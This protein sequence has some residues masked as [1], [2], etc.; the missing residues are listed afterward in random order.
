MD[1]S[2]WPFKG[3]QISPLGRTSLSTGSFGQQKIRGAK[4]SS[5][6]AADAPELRLVAV[7]VMIV[8]DAARDAGKL[9]VFA[10][11]RKRQPVPG[12]QD[13]GGWPDFK[14]DLIEF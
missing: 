6:D 1:V 10:H 3:V 9:E 2:L 7:V 11:K 12:G 8:K 13:R 5:E 4:R 14:V